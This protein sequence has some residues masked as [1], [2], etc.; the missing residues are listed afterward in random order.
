M[1]ISRKLGAIL[2]VIFAISA[3]AAAQQLPSQMEVR[4]LEETI[5]L[6]G[7]DP[8]LLIQGKEAQGKFELAVTRGHFKYL[9]ARAETKAAFEKNPE[10]YEVQMGGL[11]ARMGTATRGS[12]DLYAVYDG[13]IYLFGTPTCKTDFLKAPEQFLNKP[14]AELKASR[15]AAQ[16]GRALLEQA[17]EALGGAAKI[18]SIN[19]YRQ[20]GKRI[21]NTQDGPA[22]S[23]VALMWVRSGRVR[24]ERSF[25]P[26]HVATVLTADDAFSVVR[27]QQRTFFNELSPAQRAYDMMAYFDR[28]LLRVL[29][30]R[31]A[32][33]FRV[34]ALDAAEV[35]GARVERVAIQVQGINLT[36]GIDPAT[37]RVHSM[38][39]Q[40]RGSGGIVAE[41][42]ELYSDYRG[43]GGLVLPF[44]VT[45]MAG[46]EEIAQRSYTLASIAINPPLEASLFA[47]PEEA[48]KR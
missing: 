2:A 23:P 41:L 44:K 37:H 21:L 3:A 42:T 28:T 8:V 19:S 26:T 17:V 9:F 18:D 16:K 25:G 12:A 29:Q 32:P 7:L 4:L 15:R 6:E 40:D 24:E 34:A 39:Y 20:Q 22:E 5:L 14:A 46:G 38:S 48:R 31:N 36:L 43:V 47:R 10:K 35:G 27:N 13:K 1:R 33:G 45:V 30:A 11:C